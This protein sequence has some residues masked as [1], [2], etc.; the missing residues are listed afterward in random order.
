VHGIFSTTKPA[1]AST[2]A[3][4][5]TLKNYQ[6]EIP[7]LE[8]GKYHLFAKYDF[9]IAEVDTTI[10]FRVDI[11]QDKYLL[12]YMRVRMIDRGDTSKKYCT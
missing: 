11:P 12:K 10:H 2:A 8:K 4:Q 3:I 5:T 9:Q 1:I 7:T 6:S